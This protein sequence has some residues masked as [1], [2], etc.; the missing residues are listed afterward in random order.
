VARIQSA[1][2][3]E[4]ARGR[5]GRSPPI[6]SPSVPVAKKKRGVS[7]TI[8]GLKLK[9]SELEASVCVAATEVA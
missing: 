5:R 1:T 2:G 6:E 4:V 8:D 7:A 3:S 9:I